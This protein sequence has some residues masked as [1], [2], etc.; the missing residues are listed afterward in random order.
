MRSN[1]DII[2]KWHEEILVSGD[3]SD[4]ESLYKPAADADCLMPEGTRPVKEVHE[5]IYV[6]RSQLSDLQVRVIHTVGNGDWITAFVDMHGFKLGTDEPVY[7]R[8]LTLMRV[9]DQ[10][11]VESYP[12]IDFISFFEQLGHLP[13]N[14]FELLLSGTDL[15]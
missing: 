1:K 3:L 12:S 15:R 14:A 8:W 5:L 9:T 7:L 2:L 6:L 11:I 13:D 10:H 4:I